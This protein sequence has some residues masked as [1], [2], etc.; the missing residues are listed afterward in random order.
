MAKKEPF[1]RIDL[2]HLPTGCTR[3]NVMNRLADATGDPVNYP[4][5]I[6]LQTA[7]HVDITVDGGSEP[8]VPAI[9]A[10]GFTI[11]PA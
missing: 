1:I 2:E 3:N 9:T 8:H 7:P 6:D 11:L 4:S 5:D 10:A